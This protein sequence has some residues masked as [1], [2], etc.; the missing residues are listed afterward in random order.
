ML[1]RTLAV[2]A[3]AVSLLT[4]LGPMQAAQAAGV[5]PI[6][7]GLD[8]PADFTVAADGSIVYAET[9][10]ARVSEFSPGTGKS[11]LLIALPSASAIF[12]V[13]IHP[14]KGWIYFTATVN[15]PGGQHTQLFRLVNGSARL[16]V[17]FGPKISG[18]RLLFGPDKLLYLVLGDRNA[19]GN[20]QDLR[21]PY[22]KVLRMTDDGSPAAGNL[23]AGSRIFAYGIR[24]SFGMGFDPKSSL[25][26]LTDNGPK[27][28]DE[29]N[30]I[31]R[32]R[33]YGW[34]PTETCATPPPAP[35][36]T[37]RDGPS[38]T[39]PVLWMRRTVAPTGLAFTSSGRL[40]YGT[41]NTNS[42]RQVTLTSN[43]TGATSDRLLLQH[44]GHV[45]SLERGGDGQMY[46]SDETSI[47][48]LQV[49]GG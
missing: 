49:A 15:V 25:L 37:N 11:H 19:S 13:A 9:Y 44:N 2:L 1:R 39:Q 24:N 14:T 43:R 35:Q 16:L 5:Q 31:R 8:Y 42:I 40:L 6:L 47:Y 48:R 23:V 20:A 33:N 3:S 21:N 4:M 27:C 26:W 29:I 12:G 34:G 38:P 28:N 32:G 18:G 10:L 22:G 17:D 30:L 41:Y 7:R 36:D 46:F 45:L